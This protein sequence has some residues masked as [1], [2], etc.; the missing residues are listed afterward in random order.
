MRKTEIRSLWA[1]VLFVC[2]AASTPT[3]SLAQTGLKKVN[4]VIIV[5]QENH[6]FDN[7]FG[8]LP[9][10][11]GTPYH[12]PSGTDGC[13]QSDHGCVDGPSCMTDATGSLHCFN[14]NLE[15]NGSQVF[16]FH[17]TSRCVSPDLNHSWFP[18]H[19]EA[20]YLNPQN[21][22]GQSLMNGFVRLNDSTEQIDNGVETPTE[23]QTIRRHHQAPNT[24]GSIRAPTRGH[25]RLRQRALA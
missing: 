18:T 19:Q 9:Y 16:S 4:H 22:F 23:D 24:P 1:F 11:P 25:V 6:S 7:Y 12:N 20:N 13:A 14:A 10:A 21:T 8:A 2:V 17:E 3:A 5:M 15:D